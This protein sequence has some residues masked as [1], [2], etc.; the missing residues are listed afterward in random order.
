MR[1]TFLGAGNIARA[2]IGGLIDDGADATTMTAADPWDEA[3][4]SAAQMGLHV[5]ED[6]LAAVQSADVIVIA[7]KPNV[8]SDLCQEIAPVVDDKLIIS[9]AAG[10]TTVSLTRW[11]GDGSPI[12]RC[13]PNT[14]ALVGRGMTGL[15]GTPMVNATGRQHAEDI[16]SAVGQFVWVDNESELDAVT[17]VSGSGPAYFFF[18]MEAIEAAAERLG[19]SPDVAHK[20]VVETALGAAM[21]AGQAD[22]PAGTL[23]ERVTSPGGTTAAAL[24]VLNTKDLK[25]AFDEAITAAWRRSIELGAEN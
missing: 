19:L 12:I 25:G 13:M 7:V 5:T 4:A 16:L 2:I 3:R 11:L 9:V 15:Y 17:A 14:P 10:I 1:L 18:V 8:V 23:R 20:L 6:N 24:D 22:V 21:M